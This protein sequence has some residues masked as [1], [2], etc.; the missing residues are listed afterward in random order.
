MAKNILI[1]SDGT[2]QEGGEGYP[3]NVYKL[4]NMVEDRTDGQIAFYDAGLG[5]NWQ[6]ITGAAGGMGVS[7]NILQC[8]EFLLDNY[9]VGDKIFLFGF[10][11]G[12]ATVRSLSGFVHLFG[13]LPKSRRDLIAKAYK[14]YRISDRVKRERKAAKFIA[15]HHTMRA[16]IKFIG[17]WDTVAAFGVPSK[18]INTLLNMVPSFKNDFHDLRL[19]D[20]VEYGY[21]ALAIDEERKT[22]APTLWTPDPRVKQVW[23]A[24]V[25]TDV[26]GGYKESG[27][28]DITLVEMIREAVSHGVKLYPHNTIEIS[29]DPSGVMHDSRAGVC[30]VY[31]KERR[32]WQFPGLPDIHDSVFNRKNYTLNL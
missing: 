9:Q 4:F 10:S 26:G 30:R 3:T 6:K 2:G 11:R 32:S 16:K 21:H 1:F 17:V 18:T 24:G 13:I 12:A 5:T 31:R 29:P 25:H 7:Q 15:K 14:I 22:F 20:S 8:Y 23:F 19:S 28:S 27:L